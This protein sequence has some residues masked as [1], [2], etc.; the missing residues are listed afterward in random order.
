MG[1]LSAGIYGIFNFSIKSGNPPSNLEVT[2]AR[3]TFKLQRSPTAI[4]YVATSIIPTTI[5]LLPLVLPSTA[6]H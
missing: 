6:L 4:T 5:L 2:L 1:G 3:N